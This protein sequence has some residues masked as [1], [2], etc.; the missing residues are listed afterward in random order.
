VVIGI[1]LALLSVGVI[2]IALE[3]TKM[4]AALMLGAALVVRFLA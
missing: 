2:A 3:C 4:G 1:A